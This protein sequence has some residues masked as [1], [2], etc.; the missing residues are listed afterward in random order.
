MPSTSHSLHLK[1]AEI[2]FAREHIFSAYA[3][4][5]PDPSAPGKSASGGGRL[6]PLGVMRARLRA[7]LKPLGIIEC[8]YVRR[9]SDGVPNGDE[10][11]QFLGCTLRKL[12]FHFLS[13]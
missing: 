5:R 8:L 3:L 4:A 11:G 13:S 1:E 9:V 2:L 10:R 7:A 6:A 12:V